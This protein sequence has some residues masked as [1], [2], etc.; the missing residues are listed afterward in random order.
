MRTILTI[1]KIA[2]TSLFLSCGQLNNNSEGSDVVPDTLTTKLCQQE[3]E[4]MEKRQQIEEQAKRDSLAFDQVLDK[5]LAIATQNF[6]KN[7]FFYTKYEVEREGIPTTVEII[8]KDH[9]TKNIPHL[10]IRRI[11]PSSIYTAIYSLKGDKFEKVMSHDQWAMEY[12]S[13]TIRDING[14]G[15]KDFVVNWYGVNGCCLKAFSNIYLLRPDKNNFSSSFTFINPTFSPK[16]R[17]IRGICYGHL[18]D[19]EMYKYKWS[20]EKIDTLEYVSYEKNEEGVKTGKVIVSTDLPYLRT[21]K[22]K[23]VLKT[24]PPEY[25]TIEGYSWFTGIGYN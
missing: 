13:D 4:R 8:L 10:I 5:A 20:G 1:S 23:R 19:T 9:F 16:E 11:D 18:G 25:Q 17:I 14:D 22:I 15:L 2:L 7:S 24:V 12:M 21:S 3:M 6:R